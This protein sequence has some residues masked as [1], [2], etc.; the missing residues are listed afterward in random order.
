MQTQNRLIF[1]LSFIAMLTAGCASFDKPT[2]VE[3]NIGNSAHNLLNAQIYNPEAAMN[4]PSE[5]PTKV[6]GQYA[7][8][9]LEIYRESVSKPKET[10][11]KPIR[12]D[13]GASR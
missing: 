5:P 6:D 9:V 12:I 4:P 1:T 10:L 13:I 2:P 8:K 7:D 11:N 3:R